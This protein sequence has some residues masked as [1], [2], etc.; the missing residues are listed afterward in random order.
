MFLKIHES[1]LTL[2]QY[3]Q[4]KRKFL[5]PIEYHYEDVMTGLET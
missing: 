5:L 1:K 3:E 2:K 4:K